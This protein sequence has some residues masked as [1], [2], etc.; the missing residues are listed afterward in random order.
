LSIVKLLLVAVG[1]AADAF[2]VSVAE[3]VA[4][5][6][7]TRRHTLR[8]SAM[9]GL[10]QGLMPVLGW[11]LGRT[12]RWAVEPYDHWVA[13]GILAFLGGKM[14]V[15]GLKA[16]GGRDQESRGLRLIALAIATSIDALAVGV[17]IAMLG[18]EIWTPALVIALVTALLCAVGVQTGSRIGTRVGSKA[19]VIGGFM[20][21][22]VAVKILVEH[23]A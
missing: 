14:V 22:A 8:V 17:T 6:E 23:M 11:S 3:G 12:V 5:E 4:L 20:L 19:E 7:T 10:F 16:E 21:V 1:L 9:F 13:F 15:S 18:V 2:A